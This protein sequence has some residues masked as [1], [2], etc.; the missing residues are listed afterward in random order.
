MMLIGDE[1]QSYPSYRNIVYRICRRSRINPQPR[2]PRPSPQPPRHLQTEP[3]CRPGRVP[4]SWRPDRLRPAP[5]AGSLRFVWQCRRKGKAVTQERN[6]F[7][8][9]HLSHRSQ[10]AERDVGRKCA[11][12]GDYANSL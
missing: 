9:E 1:P 3:F 8:H 10:A 6:D 5:F 12:N 11:A 7:R 4:V 2:Q